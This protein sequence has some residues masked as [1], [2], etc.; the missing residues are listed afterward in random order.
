MKSAAIDRLE[1]LLEAR[2]FGGSLTR[3]G[4]NPGRRPGVSTG[5]AGLDAALGG[6]W[7]LG[8]I[9]EVVGAR[10]TGRTS[11]L[12]ATIA[13]ATARGDLVGLVD[14]WD[15]FDPVSAV[16]SGVD[17]DRVLWVRGATLT[18]ELARPGVLQQAVQR[19]VRAFDLIIRAGGF[20]VVVLDV[21]GAPV[22]ALQALPFTT[23][24]RLAHANEGRQTAGLLVGERAMGRSA[25]GACVSLD[26]LPHW[27]G[28]STQARRFSGFKLRAE[29]KV[30]LAI[31]RSS[32]LSNRQNELPE[33]TDGRAGLQPRPTSAFS[34]HQ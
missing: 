1:S 10:S 3:S 29:I 9:S 18:V 21:A 6:G 33:P 16:A 17:L 19:A 15:R 28:S 34:K 26:A 23:W 12:I 25:R 11:V 30:D 27:I 24:M 8:E 13:A 22:R 5:L 31:H 32:D 20:G 7:R 2:K 4:V 14:A